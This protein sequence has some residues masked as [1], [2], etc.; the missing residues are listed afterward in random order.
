MAIAKDE[1]EK[2]AA[3]ARLELTPEE[4]DSFTRQLGAILS[5]VDKLN[6]LDT[7]DI[8]PM[9]HCATGAEDTDYSQ[10]DDLVRPG[11]GQRLAVENAPDSEAGYFK[12]PK[13]IGG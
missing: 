6:E 1:V 2:I 13:V 11:L 10:R 12:V 3:L 4:T 7:S 5:Y 8:E 9:S